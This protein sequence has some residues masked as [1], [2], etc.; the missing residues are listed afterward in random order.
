MEKD[1][2]SEEKKWYT[3]VGRDFPGF[4]TSNSLQGSSNADRFGY[5]TETGWPRRLEKNSH[6]IRAK[7][8]YLQVKFLLFHKANLDKRLL[9]QGQRFIY[10]DIYLFGF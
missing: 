7:F 8:S 3:I 10:F 9:E 5:L 2:F 4:Q 1:S 6:R